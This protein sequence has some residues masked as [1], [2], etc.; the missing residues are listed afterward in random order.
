MGKKIVIAGS[1]G[2]IGTSVTEFFQSKHEVLELDKLLGHDLA[3][4]SFVREW[5]GVNRAD[6]LVNLFALNDHVDT[7]DGHKGTLFDISLDSFRAYLE[8]NLTALFSVCRE[9]ARN[10]DNGGIVNFS[11]T[12]GMVSPRPEMYSAGEKHIGYSVTK[13]GIIQLT[14]HLAAHLAPNFRVNCVVP[15]G[16][17][18]NQG[19]DFQTLYA[20]HTLLGRMMEK[21]ELNGLLHYLCSEESAYM[22]GS[23]LV[24][25]GGW[26]TI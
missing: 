10:N 13:G 19:A 26:T 15:G 22:T 17:R 3:D 20:S 1:R 14:R 24:I 12:Y 2:L 8:V 25:D 4:E 6:Y 11:S 7:A 21:Q 5:F 16:V 18:Y 9:F 23:V